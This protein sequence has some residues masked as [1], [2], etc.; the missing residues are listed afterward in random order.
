MGITTGFPVTPCGP[1][2]A[3]RFSTRNRSNEDPSVLERLRH[4][5]QPR[6]QHLGYLA[7]LSLRL[8]RGSSAATP[9]DITATP[10]AGFPPQPPRSAPEAPHSS[11][12]TPPGPTPYAPSPRLLHRA[13][14][15]NQ[16]HRQPPPAHR[17]RNRPTPHI[18]KPQGE[19]RSFACAA[20]GYYGHAFF[21]RPQ[22]IQVTDSLVA[23]AEPPPL[24]ESD[25]PRAEVDWY[26]VLRT[27]GVKRWQV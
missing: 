3:N 24:P 14:R 1:R 8:P 20:D 22:M 9:S 21:C 17:Q 5:E 16:P 6:P 27:G 7:I 11:P 18:T 2:N 15:G 13:S 4:R 23:G 10:S 25:L 12:A 19:P 26:V